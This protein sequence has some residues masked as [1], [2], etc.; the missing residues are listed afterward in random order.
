MLIGVGTATG[1][2]PSS[3][4][5]PVKVQTVPVTPNPIIKRG[6]AVVTGFSAVSFLTPSPDRKLEDFL[7]IDAQAA[8]L[9]VFD[10][11]QMFGPD[12]S[13]LVQAPR[14]HTVPAAEIGQ[15]FGVALDDGLPASGPTTVKDPVPNIY[16]TATS[17]YGLQIVVDKQVGNEMVRDNRLVRPNVRVVHRPHPSSRAWLVR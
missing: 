14:R 9:Q 10:L 7:I 3:A 11:S 12:D 5:I 1:Q 16:A 6:D 4:P 8:A 15:V 13:R 2:Q 17:A